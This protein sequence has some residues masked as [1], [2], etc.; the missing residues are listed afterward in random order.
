[1]HDGLEYSENMADEISRQLENLTPI[2][3]DTL[4]SNPNKSK[5]NKFGEIE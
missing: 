3:L 5:L 4:G 2:D 1:M